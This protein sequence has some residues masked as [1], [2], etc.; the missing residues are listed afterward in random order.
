MPIVLIG[1]DGK[2]GPNGERNHHTPHQWKHI[3]GCWKRHHDE[4]AT[5]VEPLI[6]LGIPVLN[7]SP[8]SAWGDLWPVVSLEECINGDVIEM[9]RRVA[10][11]EQAKPLVLRSDTMNGGPAELRVIGGWPQRATIDLKLISAYPNEIVV[12]DKHLT[13]CV[14]NGFAS[15]SMQRQVGNAWLCSKGES[16]FIPPEWE[17]PE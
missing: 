6:E 12:N 17:R 8:G 11:R 4:L 7:A 15:Y 9:A 14:V 16:E 10:F 5:L 1:A 3:D 2:F 13:I